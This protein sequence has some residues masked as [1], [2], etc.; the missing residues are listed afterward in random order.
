MGS[1]Y[2]TFLLYLPIYRIKEFL[3]SRGS[4][5]GAIIPFD[6]KCFRY[7]VCK[8]KLLSGRLFEEHKTKS[9]V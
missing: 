1:Q 8:E 3:L 2:L 5:L 6:T 4:M 9:K 7:V